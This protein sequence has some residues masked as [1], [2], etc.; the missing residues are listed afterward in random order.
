[1]QWHSYIFKCDLSVEIIF[2]ATV[3]YIKFA[4]EL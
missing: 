3:G 2:M 1:M 4:N